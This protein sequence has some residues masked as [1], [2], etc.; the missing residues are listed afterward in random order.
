MRTDGARPPRGVYWDEAHV[1]RTDMRVRASYGLDLLGSYASGAWPGSVWMQSLVGNE[2]SHA[3]DRLQRGRG[4]T[5]LVVIPLSRTGKE[6]D[7]LELH[8][9]R[10]RMHRDTYPRLNGIAG[11]LSQTWID[12]KPGIF[13]D[14]ALGRR[15][16]EQAS[17]VVGPILSDDN[18]ARL[19]RAEFRICV[20]LRRGLSRQ[21]V[22]DELG[23]G[24]S[25]LRAHLRNVYAKTGVED[26][27]ALLFRLFQA[28]VAMPVPAV[29][30][31]A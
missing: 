5:E 27:A 25:T 6:L 29:R 18:P 13:V 17:A 12:R 11:T 31:R 16:E 14:V 26:H 24:A 1:D 28:D 21:S 30:Q 19:S 4:F 23:I 8:F 3:L 2:A 9:A 20:C 10:T 22:M 15:T 7:L